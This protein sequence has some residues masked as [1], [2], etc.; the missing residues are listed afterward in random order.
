MLDEEGRVVSEDREPTTSE[1]SGET[2]LR[3]LCSSCVS[4]YSKFFNYVVRLI[5]LVNRNIL[6]NSLTPKATYHCYHRFFRD[7]SVKC[8]LYNF[9]L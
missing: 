5:K 1:D 2:L 8:L 4:Q 9:L 3:G 7:F 6:V